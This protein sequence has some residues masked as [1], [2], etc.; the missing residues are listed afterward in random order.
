VAVVMDAPGADELGRGAELT[1]Y[2]LEIRTHA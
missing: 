1:Q 2:P